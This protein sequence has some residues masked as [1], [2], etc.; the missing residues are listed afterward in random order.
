MAGYFGY[1]RFRCD[2][3]HARLLSPIFRKQFQGGIFD[4]FFYLLSL[5]VMTVTGDL[6][7]M[8]RERAWQTAIPI[9]AIR[10]LVCPDPSR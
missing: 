6:V 5:P 1:I 4:P 7:P 3:I 9:V 8:Q 10:H 2:L